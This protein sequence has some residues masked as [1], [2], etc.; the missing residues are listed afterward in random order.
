MSALAVS[1]IFLTGCVW[2][3]L[4][5]MRD[6]F[7]E[8]DTHFFIERPNGGLVLGCR[9]PVIRGEDISW[10]VTGPPTRR[11]DDGLIW[12]WL[13]R[14]EPIPGETTDL[15]SRELAL[16]VGLKNDLVEKVIFPDPVLKVVPA[17]VV[18]AMMRA[19]GTATIDQEK[20]TALAIMRQPTQRLSI[21]TRE[22]LLRWFGKAH[23]SERDKGVETLTFRYRLV[24]AE[25][26]VTEETTGPPL[27][28]VSFRFAS[29]SNKPRRFSA[30]LG[31]NWISM[32]LPR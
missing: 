32:E 18:I 30:N 25:G 13:F 22:Q 10:M 1:V 4:L 15:L 17:E 31:G 3:R 29:D 19:L 7:K 23:L 5:A 9:D 27:V 8:F 12:T 16:A 6:Q 21:P 26:V 28:T 24:A 20:R 11:R 2:L 14:K